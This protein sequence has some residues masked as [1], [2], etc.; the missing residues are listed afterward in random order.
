VPDASVVYS[1]DSAS[2]SQSEA[3]GLLLSQAALFLFPAV[4]FPF[5]PPAAS[6]SLIPVAFAPLLFSAA[7]PFQFSS[8]EPNP[9][10]PMFI[11]I[12]PHYS[13]FVRANP[14]DP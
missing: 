5:S 14:G 3:A 13:L 8:G 11:Q 10:V 9:T 2:S 6:S 1:A 12:A 7:E 4:F